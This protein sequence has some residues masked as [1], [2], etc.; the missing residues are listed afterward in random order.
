MFENKVM[1]AVFKRNDLMWEY[2]K[3]HNEELQVV[4]QEINTKF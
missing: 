3:L 2:R 1:N 4:E